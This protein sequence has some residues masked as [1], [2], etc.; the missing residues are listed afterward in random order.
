VCTLAADGGVADRE[1]CLTAMRRAL[2]TMMA[3]AVLRLL[4]RLARV[5]AMQPAVGAVAELWLAAIDAAVA[6]LSLPT[7]GGTAVVATPTE[8]A[9]ALA[10]ALPQWPQLDDATAARAS[11]ALRSAGFLPDAVRA[12][13]CIADTDVRA[14]ALAE[15]AA[16]G[17]AAAVLAALEA[18]GGCGPD[19]QAAV[20]A[21]ADAEG[22]YAIAADPTV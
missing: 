10:D 2:D 22:A 5:P 1:L 9:A 21:Q 19:E 7:A 11:A 12:A 8:T 20:F 14:A 18:A 6:M 3:P 13:L 15:C 17:A 4:P 16:D